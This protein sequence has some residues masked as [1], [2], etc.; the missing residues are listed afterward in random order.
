[1]AARK[2]EWPPAE[3]RKEIEC[4]LELAVG[5]LRGA[6]SAEPGPR[7][8]AGAENILPRPIERVPVAHGHP[9]PVLH[10]LAEDHAVLVIHPI[11]KLVVAFRTFECDGFDA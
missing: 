3:P 4:R 1:W 9:Q 7:Q 8:R 11:G 5:H 2:G 10:A 6:G